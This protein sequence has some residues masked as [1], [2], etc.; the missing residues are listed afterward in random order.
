[1]SDV[2]VGYVCVIQLLLFKAEN[3]HVVSRGDILLQE[4]TVGGEKRQQQSVN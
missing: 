2:S 4:K 3:K 1:M